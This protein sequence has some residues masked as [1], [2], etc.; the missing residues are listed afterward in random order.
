MVK[1]GVV[2]TVAKL[3]QKLENGEWKIEG[4]KDYKPISLFVG[5]KYYDIYSIEKRDDSVVYYAFD[6]NLKLY[7]I[8]RKGKL[9]RVIETGATVADIVDVGVVNNPKAFEFYD[10]EG[11]GSYE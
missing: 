7:K 5:N 3:K 1:N 2:L 4:V 10:D 6:D 8:I 11:V 9:N